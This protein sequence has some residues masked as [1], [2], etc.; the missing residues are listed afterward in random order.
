VE[1]ELVY[2]L[3]AN[4]LECRIIDA[5]CGGNEPIDVVFWKDALAD[6]RRRN[7]ILHQSFLVN[8]RARSL[9]HERVTEG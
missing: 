2:Q 7:V 5:I 4:G 6:Q 8:E 3:F 1:Q 9:Q